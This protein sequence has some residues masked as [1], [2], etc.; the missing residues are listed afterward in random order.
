MVGYLIL[1]GNIGDMFMF[2]EFMDRKGVL[3]VEFVFVFGKVF[4]W[5]MC[6][7]Y[8][9]NIFVIDGGNFVWVSFIFVNIIVGDVNDYKLVFLNIL[10]LVNMLE[11]FVI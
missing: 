2:I 6:D 10:Y 7:V 3:C 1:L 9:M 11:N 8:L 5:E 4:D